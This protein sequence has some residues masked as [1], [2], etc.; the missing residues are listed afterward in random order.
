MILNRA[1]FAPIDFDGL[2]IVDYTAA[3]D[4]SSSLAHIR[5]PPGARHALSRSTRSDKYYYVLSGVVHFSVEGEETTLGRGDVCIV[6]RGQRFAYENRSDAPVEMILFH[7][8][9]F[10]LEAEVFE[11]ET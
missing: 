7:T 1:S 2:R 3:L 5:V 9:S 10:Q 4:S 6:V 11:A 8:P